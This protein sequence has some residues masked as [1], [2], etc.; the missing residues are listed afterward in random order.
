MVLVLSSLY[1]CGKEYTHSTSSLTNG[2]NL[3]LLEK[4][5]FSSSPIIEPVTRDIQETYTAF[6]RSHVLNIKS[7][8]NSLLQIKS[9]IAD[10]KQDGVV[11]SEVAK[12]LYYLYQNSQRYEVQKC[13]FGSL[14][15]KKVQDVTPFLKLEDF[16]IQ[17]NKANIC[18]EKDLTNLS[19]GESQFVQEQ[20]MKMCQALGNS[21]FLCQEEIGLSRNKRNL[22]TMAIKLLKRFK[23]E[24][25]N[26]LFSLASSH[27]KFSCVKKSQFVEMNLKVR[28][29][30]RLFFN[31]LE[32]INHVSE[33]WSSDNFKL[34]LI[35]EQE[36]NSEDVISVQASPNS[37]SYVPENDN[38]Q[39]FLNSELRFEEQKRILSH[40]FG[41]VLGFPDCYTEFYDHQKRDLVYFEM[42]KDNFNLMCSVKKG[43]AVPRE[44][45]EQLA[46]KSCLF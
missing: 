45:L 27:L 46:L 30:P 31:R 43:A 25:F 7:M 5:C 4:Q 12:E 18:T 32:L 17:R 6:E 38:R 9:D 21:K 34:K 22:E 16:C 44:Y 10:S 29:D 33:T 40:E 11:L 15:K 35:L 13:A 19:I 24:R 20:M 3:L 1:S 39:I 28:F 8:E 41:H 23:D 26:K 14:A 2:L 37:L 36:R 42:G